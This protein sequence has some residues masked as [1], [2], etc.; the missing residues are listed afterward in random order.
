MKTLIF[1]DVTPCSPL[2]SSSET[3]VDFQRTLLRCIP[4]HIT[5]YNR[6]LGTSD[7]SLIYSEV[8]TVCPILSQVN[9]VHESLILLKYFYN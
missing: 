1:W 5:L 9:P 6:T 2:T 7:H 3:W 8:S 4:E